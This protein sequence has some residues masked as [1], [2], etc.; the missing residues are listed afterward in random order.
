MVGGSKA[1]EIHLKYGEPSA[2]GAACMQFFAGLVHPSHVVVPHLGPQLRRQWRVL[3]AVPRRSG[4]PL[5]RFRA[6]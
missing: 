5:P 3:Y 1:L 4:A 6:A 2:S